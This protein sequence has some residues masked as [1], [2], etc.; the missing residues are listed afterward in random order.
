MQAASDAGREEWMAALRHNITLLLNPAPSL[1]REPS[2]I[3]ASP[4]RPAAPSHAPLSVF[5]TTW[6]MG[7]GELAPGDGSAWL[8]RGRDI[9][10][11]SVQECLSPDDLRESVCDVVGADYIPIDHAIGNANTSLGFHGFIYVLVL[12]RA[13]LVAAGVAQVAQAS[14]R[15]VRLGRNLGVTRAA[16]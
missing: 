3:P 11:I 12:V 6:N 16:N 9:Y 4:P 13:S 1:P 8:P 14:R 10:A 2:M 7:E 15:E 5:V